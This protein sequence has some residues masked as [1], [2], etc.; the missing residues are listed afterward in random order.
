MILKSEDSDK[1]IHD[2]QCFCEKR[3]SIPQQ[4]EHEEEDISQEKQDED[5]SIDEN[6]VPV[7]D[8]C[9]KIQPWLHWAKDI[10]HCKEPLNLLGWFVISTWK[11]IM[12]CQHV[13][14]EGIH[15]GA[16]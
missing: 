11:E 6:V 2:W 10:G 16:I 7:I 1:F 3:S 9:S 8:L 4:R 15:Q 12:F 5:A 14:E 13:V